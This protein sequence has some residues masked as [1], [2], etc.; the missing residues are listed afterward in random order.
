MENG[1][2]ET[3]AELLRRAIAVSGEVPPFHCHLGNAL[4]GSGDFAEAAAA[5]RQAVCLRPDY[6]E[7]HTGLGFALVQLGELPEA[8]A[9]FTA[10]LSFEPDNFFAL[11]NMGDA[12]S[13][14]GK[15]DGA[16]DA[17]RRAIAVEPNIAELHTKLG[18]VLRE[19]GHLPEAV[20]QLWAAIDTGDDDL[21]AYRT[22]GSLLRF[23]L[24]SVYDPDLE[25]HLLGFFTTTGVDQ[26]DVVDFSTALIK[27]KYADDDRFK[28]R[29]NHEFVVGTLLDDA[30]VCALLTRSVNGDRGLE[31]L[32]TGA[33]RWLLLERG[34]MDDA[35]LPAISVLAQ[36]CLNRS[37]R[38]MMT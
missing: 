12:L 28:G 26:S 37:T 33:R 25:Q 4:Q 7:A 32:L 8:I 36:Q 23:I 27:L 20:E 6:V 17:Y 10:A 35:L 30:L 21:T 5:Y 16:A 13:A 38:V 14:Q 15:L 1:R 31:N 11:N 34:G 19:Q 9:C 22:L 29:S 3:A 2:C 24:P 18:V